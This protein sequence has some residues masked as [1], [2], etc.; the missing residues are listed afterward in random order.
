MFKKIILFL[1]KCEGNEQ[2]SPKQHIFNTKNKIN[3]I[4]K[5]WLLVPFIL[6]FIFSFPIYINILTYGKGVYFPYINSIFALISVFVFINIDKK[7]RFMFGF[8]VGILWFYWTGLSFRFTNNPYFV[9]VAIIGVG[10]GYAILLWFALLFNN[11]I[12]RAITLSLVGYVVIFGFD[13]FVPDAMFAFSIF[14]VDKISF[15]II[16]TIITIIS[17]KQLRFFR[18]FAI[19]LLIFAVDFNTKEASLP[20]AKIDITQTNISQNIKWNTE[21]FNRIVEY[22]IKLIQNAINN[23]YDIVV[24]PETAFPF[25]LNTPEN[26]YIL[27]RLFDLSHHIVIIVGAQR[28]D[29]FGY[30]NTTYVF[31]DG[32]YE[33]ADKV[34]LA[35]FGEYMPIPIFLA[36]AFSKISGI[37]YATFDITTVKPKNINAGSVVF[38]NAIC[39]EATTRKIYEDNP[40]YIVLISNNAWFKPSIEPVLQMMLIK[41]YARI[42]KTIV[43]HS[44]NGTKSGIIT[45]NTSL[46]FYVK[47]AYSK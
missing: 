35:P 9:Y 20:Q 24:L 19:L 4:L 38:R 36:D 22:N 27:E 30:Y 18:F 43:F 39:Y 2:D 3:Y 47:G 10:I 45:P 33:F 8:F 13:W 17:I 40:K 34:F 26:T 37:A 5:N 15:V 7:F 14:K 29:D 32:I 11:K 1:K 23:K 44:A 41:Y 12:F 25:L 28:Y 42:Y 16:V 46:K 21:S 31:R 6:A